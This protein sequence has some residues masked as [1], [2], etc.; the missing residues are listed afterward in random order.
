MSGVTS[1]PSP[2]RKAATNLGYGVALLVAIL[3]LIAILT[4]NTTPYGLPSLENIGPLIPPAAGVASYLASYIF[5]S[6]V[7]ETDW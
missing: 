6:L 3:V 7:F 2:A 1:K 4:E 5:F